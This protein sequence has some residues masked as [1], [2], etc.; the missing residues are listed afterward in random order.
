MEK[1]APKKAD[2]ILEKQCVVFSRRLASLIREIEDKHA[3][4]DKV[5]REIDKTHKRYAE[6]SGR[7]NKI[8]DE[9]SAK[10]NALKQEVSRLQKKREL[11]KKQ[12]EHENNTYFRHREEIAGQIEA[13]QDKIN[14]RKQTLN[15][16]KADIKSA[17]KSR[18][19]HEQDLE[20]ARQKLLNAQNI[21]KEIVLLLREKEKEQNE[22]TQAK[23]EHQS[24]LAK[25][26]DI[27]RY[28]K[29]VENRERELID[30]AQE[31][32]IMEER[33]KPEYLAIFK[34]YANLDNN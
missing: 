30:W 18:E 34:Q 14:Q 22:I 7:E 6:I 11:L 1:S 20:K 29:E 8:I 32:S 24:W 13:L 21:K 33:I 9:L 5:L 16:I 2:R 28:R 12:V 19:R 10:Q 3:E 25:I 23:K 26:D 31:L 4:R 15:G 27:K 17:E